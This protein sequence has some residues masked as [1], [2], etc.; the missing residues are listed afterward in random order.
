M[1]SYA[2]LLWEMLTDLVPWEGQTQLAI[3][4]AVTLHKARPPLASLDEAR[5]P[6][7]LRKLLVECW[8][9]D[10]QRRPSA[11]EVA[12][13][14][15]LVQQQ[16]ARGGTATSSLASSDVMLSGPRAQASAAAVTSTSDL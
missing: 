10:P 12:K 16:L 6:P 4:Y 13:Q 14:L 9:H 11:A 7:K 2:V 1:Y 8:D 5:C 3:A 15:A